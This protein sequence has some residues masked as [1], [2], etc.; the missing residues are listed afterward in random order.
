MH[1]DFSFEE[2]KDKKDEQGE[3]PNSAI[4]R[5]FQAQVNKPALPMQGSGEKQAEERLEQDSSSPNPF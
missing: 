1:T 3:L 5:A 4:I 2:I